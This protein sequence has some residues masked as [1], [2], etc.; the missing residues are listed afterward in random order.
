MQAI[1]DRDRW[2]GLGLLLAALVVAYLVLVHPWW[3]VPMLEQA[4]RIDGLQQ[5]ELRARMQMT[6]AP[7]IQ[8]A[9]ARARQLQAR[10]AGFLPES[11]AELAASGLIKRLETVVAEASPGNRACAI[12]NRSPLTEPRQD[13]YARVTVQVRMRCG[14]GETSAALHALESGTPR[15]F[16]DNLNILAQRY[17]YMGDQQAQGGGLDVSFDLYGYLRPQPGAARAGGTRAR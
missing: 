8:Q 9:L 7:E 10:S 16:V 11:S 12:T 6:Q 4:D 2:L 1:P 17:F 13:R 14:V 3:T 5:R 15:L